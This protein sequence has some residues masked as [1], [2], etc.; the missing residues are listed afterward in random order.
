MLPVR[1]AGR[2]DSDISVACPHRATRQRARAAARRQPEAP[3]PAFTTCEVA[4]YTWG[5]EVHAAEAGRRW[6]RSAGR[7]RAQ[8]SPP[9][10]D[11]YPA[12]G[13][14]EGGLDVTGEGQLAPVSRVASG[15]GPHVAGDGP[16]P[17]EEGGTAR[18]H[19]RL[20]LII[21]GGMG[22]GVSGW[23]LAAAVATT[24]QLGVVSGVALD[25]LMARRLQLGDPGGHIRRAL[26]QFPFPG[27]AERVLD[28]YYVEGGIGT[29]TAFRLVP[30]VTLTPA[31]PGAELAVAANFVEV[32]LA[33]QGHNGLVGVNYMEKLQAATPAALYGAMLGGVDYV[34]MGAGIPTE[35]PALIDAF[36]GGAPGELTIEVQGAGES[37]HRLV[38]DAEAVLGTR[39]ELDRPRFLAI[40]SSNMLAAYLARDPRT[41]PDGF[42]VEGHVAG[43]H[44][45]R[46]RGA[47]VVDDDGRP[48]YGP[49]DVVDLAK[50][51]AL[52]LPFWLA[53]GQASP[54]GL[55]S[56]L[57]TGAAG[58]QVGSAF[59]L[60]E[61]SNL[62]PGLRQA[63]VE[64]ALAGTLSVRSDLRASPTGFPF[65]LAET[66][67][68]LADGDVA[69]DRRR[70][71][72]LGYL[73]APYR[74]PDG[75]IGYR[76]PAEPVTDYLR[77]GGQADD[78]EGRLCLC[79]GLL[80]TIGLG[81]R[82]RDIAL[83]PAVV[84]I[85]QDLSF[86]HVLTKTGSGYTAA[87]VVD[88]LLGGGRTA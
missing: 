37:S 33:K 4:D 72:D 27:I 23:R 69:A 44:S 28:R 13:A 52:S 15:A 65:K 25:T 36:S 5:R 24:G 49:R 6:G 62:D 16:R 66:P 75:R 17:G 41:R 3:V 34:M 51:S 71:C 14:R 73:R 31:R 12:R 8:A 83:E 7:R 82:R 87:D 60:C 68:T 39:P 86:L 54:E 57:S 32:F 42:V 56:A 80:G 76:C 11:S 79:N 63:L 46:P 21:Q 84:T 74:A 26:E 19:G 88:Y 20:P 10:T 70:V 2:H 81:Q 9:L 50:M 18:G 61:E 40:V 47:L 22:V 55:S 53:G 67:G 1:Q 64:R 85:G 77:K 35:I 38:F 58:V 78:T 45:A 43:G 29:R 59:A 48:V 30:K